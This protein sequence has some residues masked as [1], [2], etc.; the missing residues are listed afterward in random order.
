MVKL[1][2]LIYVQDTLQKRTLMLLR[3][4]KENDIHKDKRNWLGGKIEAEESPDECCRRELTEESWLRAKDIELKGILSA[5]KFTPDHDRYIFIYNVYSWSW[6]LKQCN[7]W[8]LHRID[9]DKLLELNLREWDKEFIPLL[10]K[11]WVFHATM[12]YKDG[13]LKGSKIT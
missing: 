8:E 6:S 1:A 13:K 12:W 2:T 7:E 3:N 9:C 5:P 11:P 4:K 10:F